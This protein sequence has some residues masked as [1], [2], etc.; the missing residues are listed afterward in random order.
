MHNYLFIYIEYGSSPITQ[1]LL[2]IIHK[3]NYTY[4]YDNDTTL[5]SF[6]YTTKFCTLGSDLYDDNILLYQCCNLFKLF[7]DIQFPEL[8]H[9][10]L[11]FFCTKGTFLKI[12]NHVYQLFN[13]EQT[14]NSNG[15]NNKPNN[16]NIHI[17][18]VNRCCMFS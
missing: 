13:V 15:T 7:Y 8:L 3:K 16:C 11:K 6:S 5:P 4:Y 1:I 2:E 14:V 12:S 10:Q 17:F 18:V 9:F